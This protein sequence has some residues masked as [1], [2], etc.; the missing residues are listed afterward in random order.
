M[1]ASIADFLADSIVDPTDAVGTAAVSATAPTLTSADTTIIGKTSNL[2][3][4]MYFVTALSPAIYYVNPYS[5]TSAQLRQ[6]PFADN[7]YIYPSSAGN[8]FAGIKKRLLPDWAT[9]AGIGRGDESRAF[10]SS[11]LTCTG[12]PSGAAPQTN[13]PGEAFRDNPG[14]FFVAWQ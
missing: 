1:T 2:F 9:A 8:Q 14:G 10:T 6:K 3:L 4:A 11:G 13:N 7:G 12:Q 5:T